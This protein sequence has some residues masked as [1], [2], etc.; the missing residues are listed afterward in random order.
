[1]NTYIYMVRHGD[2]PKQ[3]IERTRELTQKGMSDAKIVTDLLKK[4]NIDSVVSSPYLR[5]VQTVEGISQY[6]GQP[7]VIEED[8]KERIFSS[9]NK[10]IS[11]GELGPILKKSFDDPNF[12]VKG[13]ESN[14]ECQKRAISVLNTIL[15]TYEGKNIVIGTHGAI[16]TLMMGYYDSRF[17]LPFL[18]STSKPDIYRMEFKGLGFMGVERMWK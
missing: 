12:A 8:L 15:N 2:S 6:I 10:R 16:M 5:S 3:G 18:H 13:G 14:A 7:V 11:D 4:E 1:M 9:G 17:D